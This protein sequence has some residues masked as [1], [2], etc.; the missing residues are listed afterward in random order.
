MHTLERLTRVES[1]FT[2]KAGVAAHFMLA[3]FNLSDVGVYF[4]FSVSIWRSLVRLSIEGH[5]KAV[6]AATAAGK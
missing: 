2:Q 5:K 3:S 6:T 1:A 4:Q